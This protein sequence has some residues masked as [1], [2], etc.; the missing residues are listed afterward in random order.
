[1]LPLANA[2]GDKKRSC[3][4]KTKY[5]YYLVTKLF[6]LIYF[7]IGSFRVDWAVPN[8]EQ[9]Q[10]EDESPV[11]PHFVVLVFAQCLKNR[12][13]LTMSMSLMISLLGFSKKEDKMFGS[14]RNEL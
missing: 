12:P 5:A 4:K 7:E 10:N 6:Y 1:L 2:F 13:H 9:S 11:S 3:R 14:H 8:R